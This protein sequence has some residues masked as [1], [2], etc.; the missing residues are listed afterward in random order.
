[1][2]DLAV[3]KL[4]PIGAE[5]QRLMGDQAEID[6]ILSRGAERAREIAAPI[7]AKTYDIVGMVR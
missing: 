6:R 1:L 4:G 2:A 3:E 5:M 7:L